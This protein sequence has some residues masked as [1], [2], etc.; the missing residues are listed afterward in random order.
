MLPTAGARSGDP[1]YRSEKDHK[2]REQ[3][4]TE[5]EAVKTAR[6]FRGSD[7]LKGALVG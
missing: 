2:N 1:H 5:C 7:A 3:E 4:H 6:W